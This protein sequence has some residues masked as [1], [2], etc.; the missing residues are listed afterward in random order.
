MEEY[1]NNYGRPIQN[2]CIN[3]INIKLV[4]WKSSLRNELEGILYL[5]NKI[6]K[7][8]LNTDNKVKKKITAI[9]NKLENIILN[10]VENITEMI[11]L[12]DREKI[13]VLNEKIYVKFELVRDNYNKIM[14]NINKMIN[15]SPEILNL[16]EK[17]EILNKNN[18]DSKNENEKLNSQKIV[19]N[20]IN[21]FSF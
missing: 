5:R 3:E 11:S 21:K 13:S 16:R 1:Y 6:N 19:H 17:N 2:Q 14:F 10:E 7:E 8:N 20:L 12:I 9:I 4:E 15:F 18:Y